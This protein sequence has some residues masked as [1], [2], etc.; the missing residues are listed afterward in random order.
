MKVLSKWKDYYDFIAG[1]Y[2][3]DEKLILDRRAGDLIDLEFDQRDFILDAYIGGMHYQGYRY[4]GK[5]YWGEDLKKIQVEKS[6]ATTWWEN[7]NKETQMTISVKGKDSYGRACS[8]SILLEGNPTKEN[9]DIP[10]IVRYYEATDQNRKVGT[11][12]LN[13]TRLSDID[14][15]KMLS[16]E[17]TWLLISNWL[18]KQLDKPIPNNQTNKEKIVSKGFDLK[19]S[20]RHRKS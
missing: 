3:I 2:S 5:F 6:W 8:R 9:K 20:F 13:Y 12:T 15:H 7:K 18:S 1:K 17:D 14:F 4:E 11:K 10:I 16:P 19:Q